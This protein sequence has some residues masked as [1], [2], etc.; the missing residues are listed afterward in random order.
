MADEEMR[1]ACIDA[2]GEPSMLFLD[3]FDGA[4]IGWAERDG[5]SVAV[6][7][8]K[9][10]VRILIAQGWER[11]DAWEHLGNNVAGAW[12]GPRTP[13]VVLPLE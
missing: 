11:A 10:V 13:I 4:I 9:R 8:A 1:L 12:A 5:E 7:C 2:S 6:Y 3:E